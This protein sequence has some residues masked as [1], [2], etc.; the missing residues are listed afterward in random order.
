MEDEEKTQEEVNKKENAIER[1][2]ENRE[3]EKD[4]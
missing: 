1:G 3:R 2:S 4:K